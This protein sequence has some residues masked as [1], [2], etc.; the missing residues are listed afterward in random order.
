VK[1][2]ATTGKV[3]LIR[4]G[5]PYDPAAVNEHVFVCRPAPIVHPPFLFYI[6]FSREGQARLME[7]FR[8]SAQG[9]INQSFAPGTLI[10]LAPLAEQKRIVEK[11]EQ[12]LAHVS[13]ARARL[14]KV[15]LILNRF[16]Q[17]ILAAACSGRLTADWRIAQLQMGSAADLLAR[18]AQQEK[19]AKVRRLERPAE[20]SHSYDLP[21]I[22]ET[23]CH[24]TLRRVISEPL[25]NGRSVPDAKDGFPVLRL[26]ALKNRHVNL[27]ER[28][29]GAWTASEA[30][31]F[32]IRR[33]DF[34]V[35]RGSGSLSLVG[36][37][38]LVDRDPDPVAYPDTLIRVRVSAGINPEYLALFWDSDPMRRQVEAKAHTTAGIH[39]ISQ[40]DMLELILAIPPT[41]EQH[42]IVRRVQALF[43]LADTV[44]TQVAAARKRAEELAQ[45]ILAKAF[46]GEL[47]PTEAELARREGRDYE[48]ASIL[49]A[50]I[51]VERNSGEGER[52]SPP[53]SRLVRSRLRSRRS[54]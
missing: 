28:K 34:L 25:A 43:T 52:R 51:R 39:K 16:R 2:G 27:G 4:E 33:Y 31:R 3:A 50:R 23:W 40:Q 47:V 21:E 8:G 45:A 54:T 5:F 9:G 35:A 17:A 48:S 1:D 26:T 18:T 46:R 36:R 12:L 53:E 7:N 44:E 15:R 42:E 38:G 32:L 13:A 49:L 22:P 19:R 41:K 20:L 24:A 6:L 29:T 11:V 10:P 37:G 14:A 30:E